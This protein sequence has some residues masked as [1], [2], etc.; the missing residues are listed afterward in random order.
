M[1]IVNFIYPLRTELNL[2]L[3]VE[4]KN[5]YFLQLNPLKVYTWAMISNQYKN[6]SAI[7][8]TKNGE[9]SPSRARTP[10]LLFLEVKFNIYGK[11]Y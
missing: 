5:I 1:I 6:S 3:D 11:K 8:R 4:E 2:A 9:I 10:K 7:L